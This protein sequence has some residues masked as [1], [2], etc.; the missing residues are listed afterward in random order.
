MNFAYL[1]RYFNSGKGG[2]RFV[3]FSL[4]RRHLLVLS[5]FSYFCPDNKL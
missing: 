4:I 5:I 3:V 1:L 2:R